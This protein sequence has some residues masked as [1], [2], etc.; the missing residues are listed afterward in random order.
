M[1]VAGLT[2]I[3]VTVTQAGV[4]NTSVNLLVFLEGLYAGNGTMNQAQDEFGAHWP[5]PVADKI[6]IELHNDINYENLIYTAS[7]ISLNTNGIAS[8][9]VPATYNGSYYI[10]ILHRNSILTVT[11]TPVSFSSGT[12]NYNFQASKAYGSNELMMMDNKWVIYTGDVNQDGAIDSGDFTDVDNDAGSFAT[13]YLHTDLNG[14]GTVDSGD[15][16]ALDNNASMFV[17][18]VIP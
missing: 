18:A 1:T 2:P 9:T 13:G 10:T 6:D 3:V 17:G 14:D 4:P 5:S 12:V 7:N 11:S 15:L 16:T 8:L